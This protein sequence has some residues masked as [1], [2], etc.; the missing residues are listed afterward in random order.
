MFEWFPQNSGYKVL[1]DP[2]T[3]PKDTILSVDIETNGKEPNDKDFK[4]VCIGL[5][6]SDFVAHIYFELN[7]ALFLFLSSVQIIAH[8]G[9]HAEFVWLKPYG[10][11]I[12]QLYA[13]TKI[14]SYV[15]DSARKSHNLKPLLQEKLGVV[16]PSYSELI[17]DSEVIEAACLENQG[18]AVRKKNGTQKLPKSLTLDQIPK[19]IVAAYN[20]NDIIHTYRLWTYFR[21]T[22]NA[23]QQMFYSNIEL[24]TTRLLFRMEQQGVRIDTEAV[25]RI[26]KEESK[27][28]RAT[29]KEMF[30]IAGEF[31]PNSPKQVLEKLHNVGVQVDS[32][33]EDVLQHHSQSPLVSRLLSYRKH[34]KL[35]STYTSPI[36]FNAVR[37]KE[38]R[39]HA[40]FNQNTITGRLSSSDPINLQNQPQAVREVYT[41]T[42]GNLLVGA[43]WSN[44]EL[45]LPASF[46]GEPGF[47]EEL[48]RDGGDLHLRTARFLFGDL[49]ALSEEELKEKRAKAK[50]CNFL[51]ANSGSA[52]RLSQELNC[53]LAEAEQFY[54]A[55]WKGYGT[56]K[57]WLD[58]EKKEAR[59]NGWI[60]T[61]FGR[62]VHIPQLTLTCE[63]GSWKCG[64]HK[65]AR[66]FTRTCGNCQVREEAERSAISVLVQG[67][68]ADMAKLSALTLYKKFGYVPIL[69]VHDELV[70]DVP[71]A[72]AKLV[73]ARVRTVMENIVTLKVPL[74]TS[75]KVGYNWKEVH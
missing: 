14:M 40:L 60:Q 2:P 74:K 67:T 47:V 6:G 41:A 57:A 20:A 32:T 48:S 21:Q 11:A 69:A 52:Y 38:N 73:A 66:G 63:W 33:G 36:Y 12:E 16:Y 35:C 19:E 7:P 46:S 13:D 31:N 4:I 45:R 68:A 1:I 8:N 22:M 50:T 54:V 62:R 61:K 37:D 25:R 3:F 39:I 58:K 42:P 71:T 15:V 28:R 17:E 49:S 29:R 59:R 34:Q 27:A 18:L 55:F 75:V 53:E 24:P 10:I 72:E 65:D 56:L 30:V 70:Y 5:C 43:D 51:L 9:S 23:Q 44:I 64:K 26:H